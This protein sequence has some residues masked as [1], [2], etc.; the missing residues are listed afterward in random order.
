M[1][2]DLE[3]LTAFEADGTLSPADSAH[4]RSLLADTREPLDRVLTQLGLI[5]ESDLA[6][7]YA[8]DAGVPVDLAPLQSGAAEFIRYDAQLNRDFLLARRVAPVADRDG[9][10]LAAIVD[11]GADEA[12]AGLAFATGCKVEP[13]V[14][15]HAAFADLYARRFGEEAGENSDTDRDVSADSSRLKDLAS[16]APVVRL[17]NRLVAQAV[18]EQASDIHLEPGPREA[19]VRLRTDGRLRQIESLAPSLAGGVVSRIKVL[20]DLDIAERRRAQDG[21][22]SLPVGGRSV[23]LRVSV[24]PARHGESLVIR[25][26]DPQATLTSIDALGYSDAVRAVAEQALSRPQGLILMTGPTGSGKT[27]SLYAFLRRLADGKRKIL[28]IEDPIEYEID[29]IAQSQINPAIDITF[30]SALRSFL[31]HDPDVLMVGEIRDAETART[32]IQ[33][34]MTGHLVLS[35]VHTN[36]APSAIIR[37]M[38]MGVEGY[39]LAST[40]SAVFAQRLVR[41]TCQSCAGAGCGSCQD[42]GV[43]GRIALAEAFLNTDETAAAIHETFNAGALKAALAEQ[44]FQTLADDARA[45]LAAGLTTAQEIKTVL[46]EDITGDR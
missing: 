45:K 35:T 13:V 12:L 5:S 26:L 10:I 23:D 16:T 7:R 19:I 18:A 2:R 6:T 37:L 30:A 43:Q 42:E 9:R 32:A 38:D 41:R 28:T 1:E 31:R 17:V 14:T 44:G 33:A 27:T 39:L 40:I 21:R 22:F 29:G 8:E 20:A 25:L 11:P 34:A 15:T 4:A 46:G 24:V 3:R 36:D